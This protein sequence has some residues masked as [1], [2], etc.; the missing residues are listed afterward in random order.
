MRNKTIRL[1]SPTQET[2]QRPDEKLA[3]Q[4]RQLETKLSFLQGTLSVLGLIVAI[5]SG[6]GGWRLY[7]YSKFEAA[8]NEVYA[9]LT[10]QFRER[11]SSAINRLNLTEG[12][13]D[14]KTRIEELTRLSASLASLQNNG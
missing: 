13:Q 9:N 12:P 8:R 5:V 11:T 6:L 14:Q 3:D 7:E 10:S 4:V 2:H 1:A